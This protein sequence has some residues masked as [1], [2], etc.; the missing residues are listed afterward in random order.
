MLNLIP[1]GQLIK[2]HIYRMIFGFICLPAPVVLLFWNERNAIY[3]TVVFKDVHSDIVYWAFRLIGFLVLIFCFNRIFSSI[4]IFMSKIPL[5][6]HEIRNLI[7]FKAFMYAL[8][9]SFMILSVC[10]IYHQPLVSLV[11]TSMAIALV[12]SLVIRKVQKKKLEKAQIPSVQPQQAK[13]V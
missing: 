2:R 12:L 8:I 11:L 4:K 10:W 3:Q 13:D 9:T 5:S 6:Y 1:G 7:L